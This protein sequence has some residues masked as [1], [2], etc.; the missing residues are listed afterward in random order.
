V[1][2]SR[3]CIARGIDADVIMAEMYGKI[4]GCSLGRGAPC[5]YLFKKLYGGNAI[6]SSHLPLAVGM[7][8]APKAKERQY[9]LLFFW[10][11]SGCRRRISRS[12]ESRSTLGSS[13]VIC[14]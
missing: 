6:V 12:D 11:R 8:L 4:E 14:L 2:L 9:H 7:A 13:C 10:R 5:I 1:Y 3:T